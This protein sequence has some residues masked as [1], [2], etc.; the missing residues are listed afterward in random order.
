MGRGTEAPAVSGTDAHVSVDH[1]MA[2][3][4]LNTKRLIPSV[5]Y[6]PSC[7]KRGNVQ[8]DRRPRIKKIPDHTAERRSH[9]RGVF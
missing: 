4:S 3:I 9:R 2:D 1:E 5:V 6:R 8:I 7:V